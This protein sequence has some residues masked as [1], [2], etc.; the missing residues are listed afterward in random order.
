[1]KLSSGVNDAIGN[2][3]ILKLATGGTVNLGAGVNER[4]GS[5]SFETAFQP[6]GTY[7]S[8]QSNATFKF[9]DYFSGTGILTVGPSI[10]AGDFSSNGFVDAADYVTWRA[11]VGQPS[12]TLANDTTG[13][14]TGDE[15]YVLGRSSFG[16][17]A[18]AP[19]SE[20]GE[21]AAVPE[22]A[23]IVLLVFGLS[24]WIVTFRRKNG[25]SQPS[26]QR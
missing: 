9:D 16:N 5:L 7:G 21:S 14:L 22:S 15:K 19:G 23:S 2:A 10:L 25:L 18:A 6:N 11:N 1:M 4:V 26:S 17:P 20:L 3:T 13:A 12:Q 8:S 24:A